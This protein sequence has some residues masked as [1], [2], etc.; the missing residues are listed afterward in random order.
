V[1]SA[2]DA[3]DYDAGAD[4]DVLSLTLELPGGTSDGMVV[5][6]GEESGT[7]VVVGFE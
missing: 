6:V 2:I 4:A 7:A 5:L 3:V 1:D